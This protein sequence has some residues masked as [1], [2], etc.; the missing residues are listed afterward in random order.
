MGTLHNLPPTPYKKFFGREDTIAKINE[1]LLEGGTFIASID[2][3]G[4]I[5]KTA[6]AYYFCKNILI[7]SNKFNYIVWLSA[8]ETVFDPFSRD[9]LIKQVRTDFK[10]VEELIDVTLSVIEFEDIIKDPID[11]KKNF[12][13]EEI[14]KRE[15]IFIV[16]D[17]LESI[18]DEQFFNYVSN[19]F[20]KFAYVNRD[21]KV[22]T[23]SR[24][25]KKIAD[26]P[27]EIDGL[28]LGDALKMLKYF[29]SEYNIRDILN[30]SN[31]DNIRLLEKVGYIPLGIE[32]IIGQMALGKTRGQIYAALEGYPSVD[33]V[34]SDEEKRARLSDIILF[35][36]K[37]MYETLSESQQNVF[38]II[39]ALVRNKSKSDPPISFEFLM[40]LT[41]YNKNELENDLETLIDNKLIKQNESEY[42]ITPLAIN[43]VRQYFDDFWS[44]EDIIIKEKNKVISSGYKVF[45]KVELFINSTKELINEDKLEEAEEKLIKAL[46]AMQDS[47]VYFELAKVQWD[48]NKF[49]KAVDN[50]RIASEL[51][52]SDVTIWKEWINREDKKGRHNIALELTRRALE[53]TNADVS[54]LIQRIN[55]LKYF[56]KYE[57]LREEANAFLEKYKKEERGEEII[58]LLRTW[59]N[60]ELTLFKD[61]N[62]NAKE[63]FY[64]VDMLVERESE[65]EI[66]IQLLREALR[67]AEKSNDDN[68]KHEY[69]RKIKVLEEKIK[70]DMGSRIKNLNRLFNSKKYDEAKKEARKILNWVHEDD[71]KIEHSKNALRVLLQ[72]LAS[73][74]DYNRVIMTF[75]DYKEIGYKDS[76]CTDIYN[77][78]I[79]EKGEK[80]RQELMEKILYNIQQIESQIRDII[81]W[82]LDYDEENL[83]ELVRNKE[84]NSWISQ[85]E[86]TRNRS[87]KSDESLIHFSDLSDLRS[88]L[89]WVKTCLLD[90]IDDSSSKYQAKEIYKKIVAYLENYISQERNESFHSR[91]NLYD[92]DK[93]NEFL[94]D[95]SRTLSE[96]Q[97]LDSILNKFTKTN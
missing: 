79:K 49:M 42:T 22:L 55:I 7:P 28:D 81:M 63:Y 33:S 10:G 21:F 18:E 19:N 67:V 6:L 84:K 34:R 12:V 24:K 68:R 41:N 26:F 80:E 56:R 60:I 43:F 93:L 40:S 85:W 53:K 46:D 71:E 91:L 47:R 86:S 92:L 77:K 30:S 2:G 66:K 62:V 58:K 52:P 96:I 35:S 74:E 27:I 75:G 4:G 3:V 9:L 72:I 59:K 78:A 8:K 87:L 37:N 73:E 32:F 97:K 82:A 48:L 20:N 15:R 44:V 90:K 89:S 23:T 39:A 65:I 11:K 69:I 57:Q 31:H 1:T 95:T 45:D 38:K 61:E 54:I 64:L 50:F 25:R 36:F 13:E 76:N 83:L 16:L 17:N 51:N 88:L 5:G 14:F 94:V 70:R 29:A